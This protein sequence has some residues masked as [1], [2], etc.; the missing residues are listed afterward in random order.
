MAVAGGGQF[1]PDCLAV[2]VQNAGIG[3]RLQMAAV[4]ALGDSEER[5]EHS[6]D[7]AGGLVEL[8]E[9]GMLGPR[10]RL[11]MKQRG[12]RDDGEFGLVEPQQIGVADEVVRMVA[13]VGVRDESPHIVQQAGV[14]EQFALP[15]AQG[16][17]PR[18]AGTV[19]QLPGD[20]GH[21]PGVGFVEA[22]PPAQFEHTPLAEGC[23]LEQ[24]GVFGARQV[25]DGKTF[26][27][28]AFRELEF[29]QPQFVQQRLENRGTADDDVGPLGIEPGNFPALS[30]WQTT[31]QLDRFPQLGPRDDIALLQPT[32]ERA[33]E[34]DLG[35][36]AGGT[37]A[38]DRLINGKLPQSL[39]GSYRPGADV[40]LN[41]CIPGGRDGAGV[42]LAKEHAR[43]ADGPEL[44]RVE[45]AV[46][47]LV[48][49]DGLGAAATD[50]DEE[51]LPRTQVEPTGD[52]QV[53]Q[54]GL[55]LARDDPHVDPR[56]PAEVTQKHPAVFRFAGRRGGDGDNLPGTAGAG[57]FGEFRAHQAGPPHRLGL[58]PILAKFAFA[59]PNGLF[60][61]RDHGEGVVGIH[62][63]KK[64]ANRV[65][66]EVEKGDQF[67][68]GEGWR[69][70]LRSRKRVAISGGGPW[71]TAFSGGHAESQN[72]GAAGQGTICVPP[73]ISIQT[74]TQ[75]VA[76]GGQTAPADHLR[77][78]Q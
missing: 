17:Q 78:S 42:I 71:G 11:V 19:E 64:Q 75:A 40:S 76:G 52:P 58:E 53:N 12:R 61:F 9:L 22:A 6:D 20:A 14:F 21:V 24:V 43:E 33:A 5:A 32:P 67:P 63:D 51:R 73:I 3:D 46:L 28:P 59:Q 10:E 4:E 35:E 77:S 7:V 26:A 54:P 39:E 50:V 8:G 69:G 34:G 68:V 1:E 47:L 60:L 74:V 48:A 37:R 62:A 65:G 72:D 29:G 44:E 16:V 55:F 2:G 45:K 56:D 13:M 23:L 57:T 15:V 38:G 70:G 49:N 18:F 25:V 31:Q 30:E 41:A 27:Q 66:A 36:I